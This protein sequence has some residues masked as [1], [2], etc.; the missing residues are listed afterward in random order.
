MASDHLEGSH[1]RPSEKPLIESLFLAAGRRVALLAVASLLLIAVLTIANIVMRN[2]MSISLYGLN[3]IS[4]L[5]VA[6]AAAA[7]LPYGL[8]VSA[9]LEVDLVSH[10]LNDQGKRLFYFG[11]AVLGVIFFGVLGFEV[12]MTADRMAAG[13]QTTLMTALPVAPFF[14][15]MA[16]AIGLGAIVMLSRAVSLALRAVRASSSSAVIVAG[17][18]IFTAHML[19][20]LFGVVDSSL[21]TYLKPDSPVALA[22]LVVFAMWVLIMFMVPVGVAMGLAGL[23]GASALFGSSAGLGAI[24]SETTSF[25]VQD[26]LSVL[27]LFLLMGAFA[28]VAGI[29]ADLYRLSNALVGHIRGGLAFAS[30]LACAGFGTV[31]GSSI[32]TQMTIG[33][34]ALREMQDRNYSRELASGTIAAGGTLGQLF[35]PSSALILYAVMTEQSIG[36]LFIGALIPAFLA[37]GLY[38]SAVAIWLWLRPQDAAVGQR[39]NFGEI[40]NAVKGSWS[41]LLLIG[42]VLGGIYFGLFTEL[43]A[44]AVGAVGAFVI[45]LARGRL[46]VGNFWQTIGESTITLAMVYSL[47]F[48]AT[49]LTFFFG[50]SGV[51]QA[52]VDF[53][54]NFELGPIGIVLILIAAYLV[55]GTF[56]DGFAMMLIT[57]PIFV[58]LVHSLG[59]DPIWWG[60]MTLICMEA[61]QISPP[62]GLNIFVISSLDPNISLRQVYRGCWPFFASTIMK[63]ALLLLFPSLVTWLPSAMQ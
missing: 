21:Y 10:L 39:A 49:M 44:G 54:G 51:P 36:R 25:I 28:S 62:F 12:W 30:I 41:V 15:I 23:V 56:M 32:V 29:G 4:T 34:I 60:I 47:L 35:P 24:G 18:A 27:P 45:A 48:G 55:L 20:A 40:A 50:I 59:F 17:I 11:A 1:A 53:L 37:A 8:A 22:L 26:S 5:L 16:G 6:L 57:I 42:I 46:S 14:R 31:T 43:E 38:M 63:I 33:R 61:G 19:L 2:T 13:H 52:F 3:E 9:S 58:P 7:C